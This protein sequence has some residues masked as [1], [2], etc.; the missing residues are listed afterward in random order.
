MFKHNLLITFRGFL[1]NK[2][3]FLIN[4]V[5]LSSGLACVLLIYLWVSDELSIDQFH[6]NNGQLYQAMINFQ[7][8]HGT[9]TWEHTPV[10]L[11]DAL[12]NEFPEVQ[13]ATLTNNRYRRDGEILIDDNTLKATRLFAD[14][15]FF[16]VFSYDLLQG[17]HRQVLANK[18]NIVLSEELAQKLFRSTS[19]VIGKTITWRNAYFE[20]LFQV[21]GIFATPP[22]NST[23][24]FDAVFH[25]EWM[26]EGDPPAAQWNATPVETYVVLKEGTDI[27]N[28]SNKIADILE[29]KDPSWEPASLFIQQFSR[30]YLHGNYENGKVVGG[31]IAYVRL[32]SIIGLFILMI[33]CINFMNLS[34]A[35]ASRKLKEIGVKKA[36]G[37]NRGALIQQYLSESLLM[38]VL[39]LGA[40]I[41]FVVLSLSQFNE[42]TGK[43]LAL[44]MSPGFLLSL[45]GIVV[46]TGFL[47]GS[48]PSFYLSSFNAVSVLK[49]K[50]TTALGE[51]W[52]RKGLVVF[53]FALSVIF[54]VGVLVVNRQM[55]YIQSKNLGYNRDNII[56]FYRTH[57]DV[58]PEPFLST[59]RQ[60]SGVEHAATVV[61][62]ILSGT[63]NNSG[64]S[65]SGNES[66]KD[67][68]FKSP[69]VGYDLIETLDMEILAG[70]SFSR[71]LQD[72][73]TKIVLNESA[74]K[75][76]QLDDPIG[77]QIRYGDGYR[78]IIGVV[79]DFHYGSL[80]HR[81]EPL[82]FRY[83]DWGWGTNTL[84]KL[85][86]GTEEATINQIAHIYKDF[87]PADDSDFEFTYLDESYQ[88]LY[89]AEQ[90]VA[91]LSRYF[92]GLAIIV[93]CLGL[94][95]LA[96]FS[97][98]RRTKEIGIR[99]VL[100]STVWGV[101]R[102]LSTD[103]TKMVIGGIL[104]ALP[105]SYL[106]ARY[107]LG[108]FAYAIDLT[109][110][111]F[112]GAALLTLTIAW[113]VVGL[114]T[115]KAASTNP[116][117][118]LQHE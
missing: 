63:G 95:G 81:I 34:T 79:G 50:R 108:G 14:K 22:S 29:T 93:S 73:H 97:A 26:V 78:E 65:W 41:I 115:F 55:E 83:P 37:A 25:Y 72:D 45:A 112:A 46:C 39:S 69:Q 42:I 3:S 118:C 53:Q 19:D 61:G 116:A 23:E 103:F 4:L 40:A 99:K 48:Y 58:D 6:E 86:A 60:L 28:F 87:H 11:A 36:I 56:S 89:E 35:Q 44:N 2:T 27:A 68:V 70:R 102:L 20:E 82:I 30:R 52:V 10:N 15:R 94:F 57:H 111:F 88:A 12:I 59:V 49:G 101:V 71:A 67:W 16:E 38:V 5:G 9:D 90:R 33:A 91:V 109:V 84:V 13:V 62:S 117:K 98:E 17:D 31:R 24:Q 1:R 66:D 74:L 18:N 92:S 32:F 100:G 113:V 21:S 51:Q 43:S 107:W 8:P 105:I 47:A 110:W 7:N 104:L 85:K 54:I 106:L 75:M 64:F 77:R 76:M 114:Q 80:H 96:V